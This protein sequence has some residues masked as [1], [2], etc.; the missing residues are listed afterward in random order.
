MEIKQ[1]KKDLNEEF[2]ILEEGICSRARNLLEGTGVDR[3]KLNNM[4]ADVLLAQS[5]A[6]EDKQMTMLSNWLLSTK[7]FVSSTTRSLNV[8]KL[9]KAM[10]WHQAC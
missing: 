6:D 4:R 1:A 7:K 10:I 2:R 3:T 9:S 8:A 5:V